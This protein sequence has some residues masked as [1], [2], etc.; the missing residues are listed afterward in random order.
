MF[1]RQKIYT[2]YD[3]ITREDLPRVLEEA[4]SVHAQ[5]AAEID[6]LWR[7][8]RGDQPIL[9]RVKKTRADICNRVVENHA[10]EIASF[11][12]S[13]FLGEPAT[14][15]RRGDSPAAAE[16]VRRLNRYM[17]QLGKSA[18]DKNMAT[19]MAVAG[20]GY[21]MFR[22]LPPSEREPGEPPFAL[23]TPDPQQSF[24]VYWS[25]F[26]ERPVL[27][28]RLIARKQKD[29][30]RTIVC[31]YTAEAYFEYTDGRVTRW[32][33]HGLG[34]VPVFEYRLNMAGLGSFE[35]AIPLLD[36]INTVASN[37][38][39]GI[40][41]F[42]QA[43]MKFKNC[44]M[45]R[46]KLLEFIDL[47]AIMLP[48]T[49]R[50]DADLDLVTAELNQTQTQTL[51][52]YMYDQVLAICGLPTSTKGGASTSDT[53]QAVFLRDGWSQCEARA[54]DTELIWGQSER[55]FLRLLLRYL[56]Q[57]DGLALS[58]GEVECKFIRRQRD[59]LL[60]KTQGLLHL[61]EAGIEPGTAI[62]T[63]GL[64]GDPM[65]VASA[66]APYLRKWEYADVLSGEGESDNESI[67]PV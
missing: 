60:T 57:V 20:V 6:T 29:S 44:Q 19:W 48:P 43:F 36:A 50:G 46:N 67:Q 66:S 17:Q 14:Y 56:G 13:N 38:I 11:T 59:N 40:E 53:G 34:G 41:Q 25:G 27:G 3:H 47:G 12:S 1:G 62:A 63:C 8:Y 61:L 58:P 15:V 35:P 55:E 7:Y 54:K 31:G 65:D 42:V 24:V 30:V 16:G 4:L 52:D 33:A 22:A 23:D 37:R 26:G 18:L 28:A 5:N 51:V 45:D 21:R 49:E 64:W 10:L 2:A 32:E 9:H 39:D